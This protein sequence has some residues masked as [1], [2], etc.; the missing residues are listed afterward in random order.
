VRLPTQTKLRLA[1]FI[2]RFLCGC[3]ALAGRPDKGVFRRRSITYELE[4]REGIDLS[5]YLFGVFEPDVVGYYAAHLRP[6]SVAIDVGA[7]IGA[8]ALSMANRCGDTGIVIAVEP[9][10]WAFAKLQR[11][12]SLNPELAPRIKSRQTFL[13]ENGS[14]SLPVEIC[15]SWPMDA[16]SNSSDARSEGRAHSTAGA[17]ATTLDALVHSLDLPRVDLIKIDVDGNELKVLEGGSSTIRKF[18]PA[19]I[20]ELAPYVFTDGE[21]SIGR[22]LEML[23]SEGYHKA[24]CGKSYFNLTDRDAI[25]KAI[26][27]GGGVN[28]LIC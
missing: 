23:L 21:T 27:S 8:H 12:I 22:L 10:A 3:R 18:H 4:L 13:T 24:L 6:G 1:R 11:N 20:V 2:S 26:P 7:N 9:T 17:K 25:L 28:C 5:I 16:E 15:S 14:Q 19:L